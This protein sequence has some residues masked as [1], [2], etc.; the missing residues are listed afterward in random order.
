VPRFRALLCQ[1]INNVDNQ[2]TRN[3]LR[4]IFFFGSLISPAI[5]VTLFHAS[6]ENKEFM[7]VALQHPKLP[8]QSAL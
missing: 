6:L 4:G 3:K 7:I 2:S 5:K 1:D 8:Y